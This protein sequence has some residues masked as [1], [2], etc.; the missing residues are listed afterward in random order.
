MYYHCTKLIK[1]LLNVII[2]HIFYLYIYVY[3][4]TIKWNDTM[5]AYIFVVFIIGYMAYNSVQFYFINGYK[6]ILSV[7]Q[8]ISLILNKDR[9]SDL[10]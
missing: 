6:N 3:I 7:L 1:T 2:I 10:I 9:H 5:T 4:N 8:T